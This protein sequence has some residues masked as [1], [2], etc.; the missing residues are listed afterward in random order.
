[1]LRPWI[2]APSGGSAIHYRNRPLPFYFGRV[3]REVYF[4]LIICMINASKAIKN[5]PKDQMTVN[6][7][8]MLVGITPLPDRWGQP[9]LPKR[10][11]STSNYITSPDEKFS[12]TLI[13]TYASFNDSSIASPSCVRISLAPSIPI[14]I[15][16]TRSLI[17]IFSRCSSVN[18]R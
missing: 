9:I 16:T 8:Y 4:L 5:V 17:P 10:T 2:H 14:E 12:P 7:S 18:A 6:T 13:R 1:M 3:N 15:R 11:C